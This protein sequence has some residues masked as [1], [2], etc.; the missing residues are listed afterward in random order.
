MTPLPHEGAF[1]FACRIV[2]EQHVLQCQLQAVYAELD[3][4]AQSS[5]LAFQSALEETRYSREVPGPAYLPIIPTRE[6]PQTPEST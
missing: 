5:L 2:L 1:A 3:T 4:Q 6:P